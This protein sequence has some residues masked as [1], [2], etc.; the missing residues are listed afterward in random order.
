[1]NKKYIKLAV[2]SLAAVIALSGSGMML[3]SCEDT[4]EK[5]SFTADDIDYVFSN[6]QNADLYVK[7]CYRGVSNEE[8]FRTSNTGE[9]VTTACEDNYKGSKWAVANY[10]YDVYQPY[11]FGNAYSTCYTTTEACNL[12][13]KRISQLE[14]SPER[15]ALLAE[16]YFI[17]AYAYH[18]NMRFHGDVPAFW[19][20]MED[21]SMDDPDAVYPL[22]QPRDVIYDHIIT[23]M[24]DHL[25]D[26]PWQS[27][28]TYGTNER[29]T[30]NAACGI[31]ARIAL[32]A[33]GYSLRWNLETNDPGSLKMARRDDA[34]RVR[35]LYQIADNALAKVIG[36]GENYL[37]QDNSEMTGFQTVF[38]NYTAGEYGVVAPEVMWMIA[39]QGDKTNSRFGIY[40]GNTGATTD[41]FGSLKNL[42]VK[43]PDFYL[44]YDPRDKRRD[45]TAPTYTITNTGETPVHVGTTYTS[46]PGG[47]FRCQWGQAPFAAA[48]RN[49]DILMLRYSDVLLMYAETQNFLN[50]GPTAAAISALK[51]VRNR[52]GVGDLP[53]PNTEADFLDAVM[54]ERKWEL[55]DEFVLR[56]DLVRTD[57]LDKNL[58]QSKQN[59]LDLS[60]RAGAYA[61]VPTYRI[62]QKTENAAAYKD[63][64]LMVPYF[65]L[66]DPDEIAMV[67]TMPRPTQAAQCN[68]M[69]ANM[70]QIVEAHGY[71]YNNDWYPTNMFESLQSTYNSRARQIC[72]M[73]VAT[74][75]GIGGTVSAEATGKVENGGEY[76]GWINGEIGLYYGY[77]RN[78]TELAPLAGKSPGHPLIDNPRLT[79]LPGYP[80]AQVV[81]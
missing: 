55:A 80:G 39:Q 8:M 4:L 73:L 56:T 26:L 70:K 45:V 51:D 41:F 10:H 15:D 54:Q 17:R 66:T 72:G 13:I 6:L 36:Q 78:Q 35:E 57:L 50:G 30:R 5:P 24:V 67:T 76:P 52:A 16:L 37:I 14:E 19:E 46:I 49:I 34:A 40:N 2:R 23:D 21:R 28:A 3:T 43:M 58:R 12:G 33:A 71:K 81:E 61:N 74:K 29:L 69:R 59:M 25:D 32:H 47:K 68:K 48:K 9:T 1:M 38:F 31:L 22:R 42:Q 64:Y 65:D 27:E 79:Q 11:L 44:S 53:V 7:G 60:D 20:P 77:K 18:D 63:P 62:Y 75:F